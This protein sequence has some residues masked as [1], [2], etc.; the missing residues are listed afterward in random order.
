MSSKLTFYSMVHVRQNY[1]HTLSA[2]ELKSR[3]EVTVSGNDYNRAD[4]T[5]QR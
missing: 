2:R 1:A 5:S 4:Q 3:Y